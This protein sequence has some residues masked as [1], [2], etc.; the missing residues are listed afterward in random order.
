[1]IS[2]GQVIEHRSTRGGRWLHARRLRIALVVAV[3]EALLVALGLIPWWAAVALAAVLVGFYFWAG[4][5]LPSDSARQVSWIAATS[6]AIV[7]L[8]PIVFAVVGSV[9][10]VAAGVL[11]VIALVALFTVGR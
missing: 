4:R 5:N 8:V 7:V 6:Q 11:A 3:A 9:A 2:S 10:L 1:V